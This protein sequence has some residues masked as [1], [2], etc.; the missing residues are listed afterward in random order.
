[1]KSDNP[2]SPVRVPLITVV[3][4]NRPFY[5]YADAIVLLFW[6]T[7]YIYLQSRYGVS[8]DGQSIYISAPAQF[9]RRIYEFKIVTIIALFALS[10]AFVNSALWGILKILNR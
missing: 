1:M 2:Y 6:A 8:A 10:I 3:S 7:I 9:A 4:R 5:I